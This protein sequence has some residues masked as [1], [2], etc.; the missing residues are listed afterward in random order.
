MTLSLLDRELVFPSSP[1]RID[2]DSSVNNNELFCCIINT[3]SALYKLPPT[4]ITTA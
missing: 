3:T 4:D 1:T 2:E